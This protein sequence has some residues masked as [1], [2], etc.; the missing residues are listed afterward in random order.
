MEYEREV[1]AVARDIVEECIKHGQDI[2]DSIHDT[3]DGHEWMIY[4]RHHQEIIDRSSY[5]DAY[6]DVYSHEDLGRIVADQGLDS[7][8]QARA[9]FAFE[10]D[11]RNEVYEIAKS[12]HE[13]LSTKATDIQ[14]EI[15]WMNPSDDLHLINNLEESFDEIESQL[16]ILSNFV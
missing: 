3:V 5:P 9:F 12:I 14:E 11:V 15:A 8:I 1:A 13:D 16:E 6:L 4:T 10:H 2:A 7:A